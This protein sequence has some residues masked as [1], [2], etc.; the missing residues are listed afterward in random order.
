MCCASRIYEGMTAREIAQTKDV[1]IGTIKS[2]TW[3][4]MRRAD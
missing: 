4:A 2:R 3:Y 1:P